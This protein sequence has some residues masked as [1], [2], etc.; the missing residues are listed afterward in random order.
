MKVT[1][2]P[3]KIWRIAKGII[4][5]VISALFIVGSALFVFTLFFGWKRVEEDF[6]PLDRSRVGPNL[7]ASV[8]LLI[9]IT[10]YHEYKILGQDEMMDKPIDEVVDDMLHTAIHPAETA[11]QNVADD[12]ARILMEEDDDGVPGVKRP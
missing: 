6:I 9:L 2:T 10:A 8:T 12:I 3:R 5:G 11:E 1:I 7:V 4:P